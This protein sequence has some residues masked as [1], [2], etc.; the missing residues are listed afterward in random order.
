MMNA[1]TDYLAHV[2][3]Y[4]LTSNTVHIKGPILT[5]CWATGTHI[6]AALQLSSITMCDMLLAHNWAATGSNK[7]QQPHVNSLPGCPT[8]DRLKWGRNVGGTGAGERM[9]KGLGQRGDMS[10]PR[11]G[12]VLSCIALPISPFPALIHLARSTS[13]RVGPGPSRLIGE[14]EA[15][16]RFPSF[17]EISRQAHQLPCG[18]VAI[19]HPSNL[20]YVTVPLQYLPPTTPKREELSTSMRQGGG[21]LCFVLCVVP[22]PPP[23]SPLRQLLR[24]TL[25]VLS[26]S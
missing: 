9:E 8:A 15:I 18:T 22:P 14:T 26:R 2:V 25:L 16:P 3:E 20:G 10:R 4:M 21:K 24:C 19:G 17:E 1:I 13:Q 12:Q 6:P 23:L 7:Q 11:R 5:C